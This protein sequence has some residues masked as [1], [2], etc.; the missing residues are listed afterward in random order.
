MSESR[1][2]PEE[3][4]FR[5]VITAYGLINRFMA[6]HF[7]EFGIS[8]AKWGVLRT[9]QRAEWEGLPGLRHWELGERL[10][11]RPPS[12]S[13]LVRRLEREGLI[14]V[15][16]CREDRRSRLI[17]LA[18]PGREVLERVLKVHAKRIHEAMGGVSRAE[19]VSLVGILDELNT[20]L[21]S[22]LADRGD[23]STG[24]GGEGSSSK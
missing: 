3:R 10:L 19:S 11:V 16:R 6:G 7:A 15:Q 1:P 23:R 9:L 5:A 12:I 22:K 24:R 8:G 13:T 4:A 18:A 14:T 17:V 2:Q 21:R 20:H